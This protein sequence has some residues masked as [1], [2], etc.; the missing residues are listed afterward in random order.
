MKN[1]LSQKGYS[2]MKSRTFLSIFITKP[3]R[4]TIVIFLSCVP[5][6]FLSI[7]DASCSR[8]GG[9]PTH[10]REVPTPCPGNKLSVYFVIQ[11]QSQR[12]A[13]IKMSISV[14]CSYSFSGAEEHSK[15]YFNNLQQR[16]LQHY[17]D[18]ISM[19]ICFN[20]HQL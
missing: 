18:Y 1:W 19:G 10:F 20:G 11:L 12:K 16:V 5:I 7:R 6:S 13:I 9:S 3:A 15:H 4:I 17:K 14:G 2:T 8:I